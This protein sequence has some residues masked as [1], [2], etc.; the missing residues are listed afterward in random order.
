MP[1]T[2]MTLEEYYRELEYHDWYY[3][4]TDDHSVWLRGQANAER[5]DRIAEQSPE[6]RALRDAWAAHQFSGPPWNTE[7]APKPERPTVDA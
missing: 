4:Y 6:H 2:P 1:D 3:H 7:R 5:I